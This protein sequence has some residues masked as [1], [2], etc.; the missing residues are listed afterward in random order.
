[1]TKTLYVTSFNKKM[2]EATGKR[3][4]T[5]LLNAGV[6]GDLRVTYEENI[7]EEIPQK[8]NIILFDLDSDQF[9]IDWLE[10]NK[11]I[12]FEEFGG[13]FKGCDCDK[14]HP[15]QHHDLLSLP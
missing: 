14:L 3:M 8:N 2:L 10:D 12:I 7:A 9:L 13:T 15:S 11:D 5:Y 1:M 4:I 6:E